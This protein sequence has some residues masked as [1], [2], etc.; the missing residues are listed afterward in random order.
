MNDKI[1]ARFEAKYP[2][3]EGVEWRGNGYGAISETD[4]WDNT[5]E[6]ARH[7]HQWQIYLDA[8]LEQREVDAGKCR[9]L[10]KDDNYLKIALEVVAEQIMED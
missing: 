6:A 5:V 8:C 2:V 4:T 1:R 7:G 10:A 9:Q 3:P